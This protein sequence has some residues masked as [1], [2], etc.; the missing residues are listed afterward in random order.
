MCND[1][2]AFE[3]G[4]RLLDAFDISSLLLDVLRQSI[5]LD[6]LAQQPHAGQPLRLCIDCREAGS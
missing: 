4:H 5:L 6:S 2:S 1:F 3:G